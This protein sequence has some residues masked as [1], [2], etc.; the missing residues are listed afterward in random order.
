MYSGCSIASG[1][2]TWTSCRFSM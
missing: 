1:P 2:M